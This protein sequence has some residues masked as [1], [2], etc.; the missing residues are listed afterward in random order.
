MN[1]YIYMSILIILKLLVY[2]T[3]T[4]IY[5]KIFKSYLFYLKKYNDGISFYK[6][7]ILVL[8]H[9]DKIFE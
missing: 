5:E 6:S 1:K 8:K 9:I 3:I 4:I 2:Y 7:L